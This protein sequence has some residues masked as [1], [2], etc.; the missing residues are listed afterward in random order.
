MHGCLDKKPHVLP[1]GEI[2][3]FTCTRPLFRS[4]SSLVRSVRLRCASSTHFS[5][6]RPR[7]VRRSRRRIGPVELTNALRG[8]I[9]DVH[10]RTDSSF[11][12]WDVG[13]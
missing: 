9:L 5:P 13:Y 6:R 12:E 10:L 7:E 2:Q 11:G 8:S 3:H 1:A 4:A